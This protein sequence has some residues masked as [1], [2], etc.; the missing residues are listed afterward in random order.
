MA[1]ERYQIGAGAM[2][3]FRTQLYGNTTI[4]GGT[5]VAGAT[6]MLSPTASVTVNGGRSTFRATPNKP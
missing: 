6:N 2:T 4:S 3:I 5:L 1:T